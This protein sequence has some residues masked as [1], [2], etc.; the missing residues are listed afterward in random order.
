MPT[1]INKIKTA[2]N[3]VVFY[4]SSVQSRLITKVLVIFLIHEINNGL[5]A[6]IR[7]IV[8]ITVTTHI[9]DG[10]LYFGTKEEQTW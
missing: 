9:N 4:V 2:M 6:K 7:K 3:P 1:R 10:V 5:P 8:N